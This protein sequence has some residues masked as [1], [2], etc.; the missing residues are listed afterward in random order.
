[1]RLSTVKP[2]SRLNCRKSP[3]GNLLVV[4]NGET[5]VRRRLLAK[6]DMTPFLMVEKIN[7]LGQRLNQLPT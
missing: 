3:F 1:M 4:R 6:N 7:Y 2:L 5:A